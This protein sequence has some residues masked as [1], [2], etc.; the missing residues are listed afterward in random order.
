M[1]ALIDVILPKLLRQASSIVLSLV[2]KLVTIDKIFC[3]SFVRS[4]S[5]AL[6]FPISAV[7]LLL[8]SAYILPSSALLSA[9][10]CVSCAERSL[11]IL[12]EVLQ[13]VTRAEGLSEIFCWR[14]CHMVTITMSIAGS[15]SKKTAS[16][17][18][19]GMLPEELNDIKLVIID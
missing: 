3:G 17:A 6:I 5:R 16:M 19:N 12:P 11:A 7:S 18:Q 2:V 1:E 15:T 8:I 9:K 10:V 14:N 4:S 13:V